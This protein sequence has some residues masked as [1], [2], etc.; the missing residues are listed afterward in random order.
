MKRLFTLLCISFILFTGCKSAEKQF[1]QGD[2][3]EAID[4]LTKKLQRNA[5]NDEYILLL[6][7]AFKRANQ[8][9][10]DAIYQLHSEGQPGRWESVYNLYQSIS[11]RQHKIEPLLPLIVE[12]EQREAEFDFVNVVKEIGKARENMLS[13]W[14]A[15]AS[16]KLTSENKYD[17]RDAFYELQKIN[18]FN[19]DYKDVDELLRT[20]RYLG[21]NEVEFVIENRSHNVIPSEIYTAF[22]ELEPINMDGNWFQFTDLDKDSEYD[23]K[24]VLSITEIHAYPEKISNNHYTETKE[25][26]DGVQYVLDDKGNVMKDSLGNPI[27]VPKY[28]LITALVSETW[29]E[30]IAG[31]EG[32]IRYIDNVTGRTLKVVPLKGDGIF[33]NYYATATGYYEALSN[34]SRQKI[35]GRPL[36]FPTDNELLMQALKTLESVMHNVMYDWN[37]DILN[38]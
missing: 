33:Q 16:E 25:V 24:V 37:D 14:Y 35:G 26:E 38:S 22:D 4:L 34:Q 15:H 30:K 17:A 29:Q 7:E 28:E 10:L 27:T 18:S 23:M 20:A 19:A 12:D 2:Y 32:E 6:E 3:E 13:Y 5:D 11:R 31:I 1:R 36:P 8:H 21:T 9:D